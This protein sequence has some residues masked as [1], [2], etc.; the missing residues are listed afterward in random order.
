MNAYNGERVHPLKVWPESFDDLLAER[1]TFEVRRDDRDYRVGD[2]LYLMEWN[3][4][5][6]SYTDRRIF[7]RVTFLAGL[8]KIG[9]PGFVAM[10]LEH[11]SMG[12]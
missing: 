3:P 12:S 6:K 4:R 10:Q 7:R 1:K 9:C 11:W 8:E 2:I 5:T